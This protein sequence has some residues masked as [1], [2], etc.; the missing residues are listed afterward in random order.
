MHKL[1]KLPYVKE[2]TIKKYCWL[3]SHWPATAWPLQL[4]QLA[5]ASTSEPGATLRCSSVVCVS[6]NVAIASKACSGREGHGDYA[7]P[8]LFTNFPCG[9]LS[10]LF[11]Q[12]KG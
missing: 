5:C 12:S 9:L 8:P 2:F 11:L 7:P 3:S 1:R 10:G 4:N 6:A